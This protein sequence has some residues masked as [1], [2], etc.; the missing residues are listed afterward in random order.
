MGNGNDYSLIVD[1][2]RSISLRSC[3]SQVIRFD[4]CKTSSIAPRQICS[5]FH[6]IH[7]MIIWQENG[8]L[9]RVRSYGRKP[10]IFLCMVQIVLM[11]L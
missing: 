1:D 2:R 6:E 3:P 9:L 11:K 4:Y 7:S 8:E 10:V 5:E